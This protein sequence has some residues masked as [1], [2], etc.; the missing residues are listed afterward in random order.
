MLK[1]PPKCSPYVW[2]QTTQTS[3]SPS[4]GYLIRLSF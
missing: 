2:M 4:A 3:V 1:I